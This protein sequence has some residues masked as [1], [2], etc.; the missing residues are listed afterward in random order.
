MKF[1]FCFNKKKATALLNK[2]KF[3]GTTRAQFLINLSS[4]KKRRNK[5]TLFL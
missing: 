5:K 2:D 3:L 4:T 1:N